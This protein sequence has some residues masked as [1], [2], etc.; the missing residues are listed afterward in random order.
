MTSPISH[1]TTD[2]EVEVINV[3]FLLPFRFLFFFVL[4]SIS[5]STS[6]VVSEHRSRDLAVYSQS[7]NILYSTQLALPE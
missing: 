3:L 4:V 2:S 5:P 7:R 6:T 1:Y